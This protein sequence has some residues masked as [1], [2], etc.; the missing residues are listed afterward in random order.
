MNY[1]KSFV[2]AIKD[3]STFRVYR[4]IITVIDNNFIFMID[5]FISNDRIFLYY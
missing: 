2:D 1:N 5:I 3:N 4:N